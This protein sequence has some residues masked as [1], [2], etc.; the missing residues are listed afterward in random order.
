MSERG[1]KLSAEPY[2][3]SERIHIGYTV[4]YGVLLGVENQQN[5]LG[6][7]GRILPLRSVGIIGTIGVVPIRMDDVEEGVLQ[8]LFRPTWSKREH[9]VHNEHEDPNTPKNEEKNDDRADPME[10]FEHGYLLLCEP[11]KNI[12]PV[13]E[14]I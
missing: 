3:L 4:L 12:F 14:R 5:I 1:G 7:R 6:G 10:H 13:R 11:P 8:E 2:R 9:T